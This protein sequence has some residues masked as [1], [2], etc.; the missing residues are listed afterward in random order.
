LVTRL[1][2]GRGQLS[3]KGHRV[4]ADFEALAKAAA[5]RQ[6]TTFADYVVDVVTDAA[7]RLL[8]GEPA[9]EAALPVIPEPVDL[10]AWMA[11]LERELRR[12]TR[13]VRAGR[14]R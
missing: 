13:G 7:Q 6:G 8:K 5:K 4:T 10:P 2:D 9:A 12:R 3:I 14:R 11:K 1:A